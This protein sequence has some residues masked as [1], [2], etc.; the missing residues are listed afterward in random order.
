M[1]RFIIFW[2]TIKCQTLNVKVKKLRR[3]LKIIK[4]FNKYCMNLFK[5]LLLNFL[6]KS[7]W[8]RITVR[9][10]LIRM[11]N[12][13]SYLLIES[14]KRLCLEEILIHQILDKVLNLKMG[15]YSMR[16][17]SQISLRMICLCYMK[18]RLRVYKVSADFWNQELMSWSEKIS[19]TSKRRQR[20][21]E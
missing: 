4:R 9:L 8:F 14:L 18:I 11:G 3:F 12:W 16:A 2:K 10:K 21:M 13:F 19:K 17:E 5:I 20:L 1:Q 7:L 6:H 15:P